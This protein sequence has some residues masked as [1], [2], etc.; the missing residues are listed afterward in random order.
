MIVE[1]DLREL[2]GYGEKRREVYISLT[3]THT[4]MHARKGQEHTNERISQ[5]AHVR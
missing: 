4:L 3:L 5:R 2:V 1:L